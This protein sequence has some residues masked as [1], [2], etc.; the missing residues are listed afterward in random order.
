MMSLIIYDK[1]FAV[2]IYLFQRV[3]V[4][5]EEKS[6]SLFMMFDMLAIL[7]LTLNA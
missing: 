5:S 2:L 6:K 3:H 4:F 7:R 1:T